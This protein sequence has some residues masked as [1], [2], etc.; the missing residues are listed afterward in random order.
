GVNTAI[1]SPNGGSIGIGFAMS[2]SVVEPVVNQLREF[3]ETRRGWLGVRIQPVDEDVAAALGLEEARGA[4]VA[5]VTAGGPAEVA[6]IE[7][8][9]VILTFDGEDVEEMRDLPRM[10]AE[11]AVGKAVRVVLFRDGETQ[12]VRVELGLLEASADGGAVSGGGEAQP[13]TRPRE[14]LGMT[15]DALDEGLRTQYGLVGEETGVVVVSV[16]PDSE[17]YEKSIREGDLITEVG[18]EAVERPIDVVERVDAAREAGRQSILFLVRRE[19]QSRFVALA[20]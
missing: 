16:D 1:L 19:G 2:S 9:D 11:T 17:A 20:P 7:P 6:G 3:G 10:V 13:D 14:V 15:V 8:G 5:D 4:L 12:T 18:Q